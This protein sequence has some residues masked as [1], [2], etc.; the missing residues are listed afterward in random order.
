[1]EYLKVLS[2]TYH[3]AFLK[4]TFAHRTARTREWASALD[5]LWIMESYNPSQHQIKMSPR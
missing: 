4:E 5:R 3:H 2:L 1:M